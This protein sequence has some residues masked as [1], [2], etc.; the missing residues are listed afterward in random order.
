MSNV[1]KAHNLNIPRFGAKVRGSATGQP[2]MVLFDLLGRRWAMGIIWNLHNQQLT[3]RA[4]QTQCDQI[5]PTLLN[6]R[7]KE[8]RAVGLVEKVKQGYALTDQGN[9]LYKK[10][11]PLGAWAAQWVNTY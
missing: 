11:D 2:I 7:L 1:E 4:L 9:E 8:L 3:F 10:L 5:S 6:T